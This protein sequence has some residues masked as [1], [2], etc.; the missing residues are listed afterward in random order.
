MPPIILVDLRTPLREVRLCR[1]VDEDRLARSLS[2]LIGDGSLV[3]GPTL[4]RGW[5]ASPKVLRGKEG[6]RVC[7][8]TRGT[9]GGFATVAKTEASGLGGS[10]GGVA[11]GVPWA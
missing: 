5:S 4:E 3:V 9:C 1:R 8:L 2:P 11:V 10:V 6:T 7:E